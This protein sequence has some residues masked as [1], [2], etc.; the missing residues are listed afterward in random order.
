LMV[1]IGG[2]SALRKSGSLLLRKQ[3]P[4]IEEVPT[5]PAPVL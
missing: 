5:R 3:R 4:R 2:S 1:K